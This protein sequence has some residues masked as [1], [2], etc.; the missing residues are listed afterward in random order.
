MPSAAL[1]VTA[2]LFARFP[3]GAQGECLTDGTALCLGC[4]L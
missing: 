3:P 1:N 4:C 2:L